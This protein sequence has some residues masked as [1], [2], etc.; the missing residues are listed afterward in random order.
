MEGLVEEFD[1][2]WKVM[3]CE[4]ECSNYKYLEVMLFVLVIVNSKFFK[5][6]YE[7]WGVKKSF[8]IYYCFWRI[9]C[10]RICYFVVSMVYVGDRK[11]IFFLVFV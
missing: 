1:F 2:F 11:V 8:G 3:F 10:L 4:V 6:S 5:L 7:K 9:W